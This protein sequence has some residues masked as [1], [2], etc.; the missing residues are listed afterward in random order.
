MSKPGLHVERSALAWSRTWLATTIGV[1]LTFRLVAGH[2][3]AFTPVAVTV[4]VLI[5]SLTAAV[6]H[7]PVSRAAALVILVALVGV[8]T[9]TSALSRVFAG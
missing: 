4:V 2:E 9:A 6:R 5:G 1:A 3:V 7:H 8:V